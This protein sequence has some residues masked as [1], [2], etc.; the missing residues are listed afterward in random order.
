MTDPRRYGQSDGGRTKLTLPIYSTTNVVTQNDSP[1]DAISDLDNRD[2]DTL[3]NIA[4]HAH[5]NHLSNDQYAAAVNANSPSAGNP[6][7]TDADVIAQSRR[8]VRGWLRFIPVPA[9]TNY[10]AVVNFTT[11]IITGDNLFSSSYVGSTGAYPS[12]PDVTISMTKVISPQRAWTSI[13]CWID[14]ITDSYLRVRY[15][16]VNSD[17]L[18]ITYYVSGNQ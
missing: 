15:Y 6:F 8:V 14:T 13:E 1:I 7:A 16:L 5:G 17:D 18:I 9:S 3:Q 4:G 11:G 10:F 2:H 12:V